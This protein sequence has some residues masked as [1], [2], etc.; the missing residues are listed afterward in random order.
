MRDK[1]IEVP[2]EWAQDNPLYPSLSRSKA[3][4]VLAVYP[5][6][7][8]NDISF[9]EREATP[10]P[11]HRSFQVA[12]PEKPKDKELQDKQE[13]W[14]VMYTDAQQKLQMIQRYVREYHEKSDQL[15]L[16]VRDI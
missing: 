2:L 1:E 6:Q 14:E 7:K 13:K 5:H 4:V 15:K 3:Y 16:T 10:Q 8:T 9:H 12:K 11:A